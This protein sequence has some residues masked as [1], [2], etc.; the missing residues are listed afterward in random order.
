MYTYVSGNC[1]CTFQ[2]SYFIGVQDEIILI[3][4]IL[5]GDVT[6]GVSSDL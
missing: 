6:N 4:S 3:T 1:V 2:A 5:L